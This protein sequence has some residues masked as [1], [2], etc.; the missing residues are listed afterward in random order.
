MSKLTIWGRAN[1][2]NVQ[3]VL[4][5]L[6]ELD[7][8]FERID[9]GMQYGR[10]QEADYLAMNPNARVPTLVDGDY[11]LW[12]SNSIMR[13]LCMAY[14]P[15]T[16]IYPQEPKRRAAVDRWLDWTLSTVQPVDRPVFWG[17]VRTPPEKRDMAAMQRDADAAAEVWRIAEHHLSTRRYIEGDSF[18]LADI[19]IGAYARRWLGVEGITR[20]QQPHLE[21]WLALLAERPGFANI[22]RAADVVMDDSHSGFAS[23]GRP[24]MTSETST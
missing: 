1:S 23:S 4:W 12:E 16:P 5:C 8:A 21:R 13:Y 11:V 7:L 2:V 20:P 15:E 19:A 9:A 6:A 24:G 22:R 10:T 14:R 17:L 18:S 3:K